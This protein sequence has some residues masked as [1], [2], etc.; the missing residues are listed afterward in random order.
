MKNISFIIFTLIGF[1][2]IA[3]IDP[4]FPGYYSPVGNIR[5]ITA[6]PAPLLAIDGQYGMW[7]KT[8]QKEENALTRITRPFIICEGFDVANNQE[9]PLLYEQL[10]NNAFVERGNNGNVT[11]AY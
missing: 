9:L 10:N 2:T 7:F 1:A 6:Y 4:E 11:R 8:T 5:N 3:Q